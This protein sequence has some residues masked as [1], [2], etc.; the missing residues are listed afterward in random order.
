M[1][2]CSTTK[3][4]ISSV[5]L[6]LL[7][8]LGY[9]FLSCNQ[10]CAPKEE[11]VKNIIFMIGDGMGVAQVSAT[12][13]AQD[14]EPM[15]LERATYVG[16]QKTYSANSRVT[17]SAAAGT[18]LSTGNKTN[19]GMIGVTPDSLPQRSILEYFEQAGR[20][21]GIVVTYPVTN[22]TPA[23]FVAH[24]PNRNM[25]DE[26]ATY[27]LENDVDVIFGGGSKR[28]D[29]RADQVNLFD[30]L[31]EKEYTIA[32]DLKEIADVKSGNV[33][34]LP[35]EGSMSSRLDGRDEY[36]PEATA[37]A[38]EIL[39][40]NAA[41]DGFFLMVESSMIDGYGHQ[42][43]VEGI[44][45]ETKDFD[46]AIKVAFDYADTHPGTLVV[47]TADHATG[48]LTIVNGNRR[49]DLH[50]HQVDYAFTTGG[51]TGEM[52]PIFAYG[53]GAENFTGVFEN[54][55]IPQIMRGLMGFE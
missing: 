2:K 42:N 6:V 23:A 33:I 19:N 50:D 26:I 9:H 24:V 49:F 46:N 8:G 39:T 16:L 10:S 7:G 40:N 18:A 4:I 31:K 38:L 13:I 28:F 53:A 17:D 5:A 21:T 32:Y 48:G 51:H 52:V 1:K 36:L 29:Q 30:A 34:M 22:A 11:K 25:E 3:C 44:I 14:Y 54:T 45:K 41:G 27:Y 43:N 20:P 12:Q 15:Q 47:V 37:K 55:D 35:T